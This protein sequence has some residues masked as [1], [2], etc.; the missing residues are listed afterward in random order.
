MFVSDI[1]VLSD[2]HISS[3]LYFAYMLSHV[4]VVTKCVL[5]QVL[6]FLDQLVRQVSRVQL[7]LAV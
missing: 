6:V 5:C 3:Y 2:L 7:A 4:H 1:Q